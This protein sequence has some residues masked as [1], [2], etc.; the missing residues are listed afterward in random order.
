M[1]LNSVFL[2][3]AISFMILILFSSYFSFRF[4]FEFYWEVHPMQVFYLLFILLLFS[5][6]VFLFS[7]QFYQSIFHLFL[8]LSFNLIQN[9]HL[10]FKNT[11]NLILWFII[12]IWQFYFV[13]V[14]LP[15]QMIKKRYFLNYLKCLYLHLFYL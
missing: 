6:F 9:N 3:F 11:I 4:F 7:L 10:I 2:F 1:F 5:F 14:F 12:F 8:L 13:L 15:L